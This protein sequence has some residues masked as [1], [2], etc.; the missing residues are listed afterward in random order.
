MIILR[1]KIR[2][3]S[4]CLWYEEGEKSSRFFLNLEKFNGARSQTSK[5]IVND[6]EI[7]DPNKILN[8][9]RIFYESLF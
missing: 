1:Q 9:I 3:R 7:A 5:I 4:R 8:E 6:Q 2:I